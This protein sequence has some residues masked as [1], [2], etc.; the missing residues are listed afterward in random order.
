MHRL[1][2][3]LPTSGVPAVD[4]H[5]AGVVY[6][7]SAARVAGA[8]G[9]ALM[10]V[11]GEEHRRRLGAG[12]GAVTSIGLLDRLLNLPLGEWVRSRDL[13]SDDA[14]SLRL[15]PVGVVELSERGVRRT[16]APPGTVQLV[17]V[18]ASSWRT[19]LRRASAFAPFGRRVLLLEGEHRNLSQVIW[20]ADVLGVGVWLRA[21]T[22][23][24]E[25][26]QPAPWRQHY[27]KA[28]GWRFRE[29]AYQRWLTSTP[30]W[31]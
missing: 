30:P 15:A 17:V 1:P 21:S 5:P 31:V 16:L 19:G 7:P 27:V 29:R 4:E 11:D 26:L 6:V 24:E 18:R 20:E 23:T 13:R 25:L 3:V 14:Q 8:V 9:D 10:Q 28:A 12:L 2:T 22:H